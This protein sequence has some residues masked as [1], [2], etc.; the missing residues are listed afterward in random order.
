MKDFKLV[1]LFTIAITMAVAEKEGNRYHPVVSYVPPLD[2]DD[3]KNWSFQ[4]SS[5]ALYNKVVLNPNGIE[6]YGYM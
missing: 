2:T 1:I 6:K 5:V 3:F 4:E